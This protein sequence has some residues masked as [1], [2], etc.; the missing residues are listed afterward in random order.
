ME[1]E[2]LTAKQSG[3]L[4]QPV[5]PTRPTSS[6]SDSPNKST[7][8]DSG[9]DST[10]MP[11]ADTQDS[12]ESDTVPT[13]DVKDHPSATEGK[14]KPSNRICMLCKAALGPL[15]LDKFRTHIERCLSTNFKSEVPKILDRVRNGRPPLPEFDSD[16]TVTDDDLSDK[17]LPPPY[18][19]TKPTPNEDA[20]TGEEIAAG[21]FKPL[22]SPFEF[23][24]ALANPQSRS[25][26][27]LYVIAENAQHAL[28]IWQDEFIRLDKKIARTAEPKR[29]AHDPR[30]FLDPTVFED[31]KMADLY[32]FK[33]DPSSPR[34]GAQDP[35]AHL[36]GGRI[37][38]GKHLRQRKPMSKALNGVESDDEG[39][40]PRTRR[41]SKL[42][43]GSEVETGGSRAASAVGRKRR[44]EE[45]PEGS[46]APRK[47][48]RPRLNA[49]LSRLGIMRGGSMITSEATTEVET[50]VDTEGGTPA[51]GRLNLIDVKRRRRPPRIGT[52]ERKDRSTAMT[53]W[54][55]RRKQDG[56]QTQGGLD[57]HDDMAAGAG[58][59]DLAEET[60]EGE[61][62][63]RR[64]LAPPPVQKEKKR[65]GRPPG[66]KGKY[67]GA[68]AR[69]LKSARLVDSAT[70][71]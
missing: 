31:M 69:K 46:D 27:A 52:M 23:L 7:L 24:K 49:P 66:V 26:K 12:I 19:S 25:T 67:W 28:K 15:T 62:E 59:P 33:Y 34:I 70:D 58:L 4:E 18:A 48:G 54:A 38:G 55:A 5:K 21:R 1:N 11:P 17:D 36:R 51:P 35:Y 63:A 45:T 65:K 10:P 22:T 47:R 68:E 32:G 41:A 57:E 13:T 43:D 71:S 14:S 9:M 20:N 37:V 64:R 44:L 53:G 39:A 50:G 30:K 6:T 40:G 60:G 61:E 3:S 29:K 8:D 42:L 16:A 2:V 56:N